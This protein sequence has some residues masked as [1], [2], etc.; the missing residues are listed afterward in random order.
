MIHDHALEEIGVGVAGRPGCVGDNFVGVDPAVRLTGVA[1]HEEANPRV[2]GDPGAG[3]ELR[4]KGLLKCRPDGQQMGLDTAARGEGWRVF[5]RR[6]Q[7]QWSIDDLVHVTGGGEPRGVG[8]GGGGAHR[9]CG[10]GRTSLLPFGFLPLAPFWDLSPL[11]FRSPRP[12]S[13]DFWL[14]ENS[15][16]LGRFESAPFV[17]TTPSVDSPAIVVLGSPHHRAK[18]RRRSETADGVMTIFRRRISGFQDV[19][20][21]C[22]RSH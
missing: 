8:A 10:R 11:R 20:D 5:Q 3:Q 19:C 17:F 9:R 6:K 12:A 7:F 21:S 15:S 16:V 22:G 18:Q 2:R 13:W 1:C 4:R 14:S